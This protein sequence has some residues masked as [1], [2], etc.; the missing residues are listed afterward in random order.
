MISNFKR[1]QLKAL[2]QPQFEFSILKDDG[3]NISSSNFDI[4]G[5]RSLK[6]AELKPWFIRMGISPESSLGISHSGLY[7]DFA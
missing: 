3:S 4:L 1:N 6:Q 5:A 2:I 7:T